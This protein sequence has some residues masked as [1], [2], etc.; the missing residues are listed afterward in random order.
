[1]KK[2]FLFPVIFLL[3]AIVAFSQ[4]DSLLRWNV[5]AKKISDTIYELRGFATIPAGWHLYGANPNVEGLGF[6]TI[7]FSYDYENAHNAGAATASGKEEQITDSIFTQKVNIYKNNITVTQQINIHGIIPGELKGTITAYLGRRDEFQTPQF[8]FSIKL[9]GGV[10]TASNFKRL[11]IST[12]DVNHPVNDCGAANANDSSLLTVFLLGFIG[13]LIALL[14]PCVFPMIPVTVSFFMKR[15]GNRALAVR[16]AIFYGFFIFLIYVVISIPFHLL[17]LKSEILNTISTNAWLN[18]FFFVVFIVFALSFFGFFDITLPSSLAGKTDAKSS[19]TNVGGIFFMALTLAI[20]SFSCTGPILGSL[21][22]GSLSGGA[23]QLTYGF[24]GFGLA[25]ALPFALFA[26]FPNWLHSLPKSGGWLDTVKKFLAFVEVALAF[27]FL[28]NADL[29]MHWG[30][31]K[32][33]TFFAVWI[34]TGIGLT[35][36]LF[37][38]LRLPHDYK[39]M[40]ISGGRKFVGVLA[41]L[42][43]LYLIPGVT[44]SKYANLKLLSGFP[45]PLIYSIYGKENVLNKGLEANVV[46]DYDKALQLARAQHKPLLIDFTGWACV[47]CRK[48]EENVWTQPEVYSYIKNNYILVSLYVDDRALLPVEQR[49]TYKTSAGFDKEIRTIGDKWAT[50]QQENFTKASQP[51]YAILDNNER[52]MNHPVGYTPDAKEYLQWLT[53]GRETFAPEK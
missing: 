45:P 36:Y 16:N 2:Y 29:V 26:V 30:L 52:L 47:N 12:I 44:S 51:L 5:S 24:A 14:T 41:L 3:T 48:M 27:K 42:F 43:T 6:E 13:G 20:V 7:Q 40:K 15:S 50:F 1:M 35:L 46:N 28:S 32:R 38:V 49:F 31:L 23:W 11:K 37:G 25:L 33:E 4:T 17:G 34:L 22:V 9:E 21:L 39:G 18:I 8:P 10:A 53:C 19:I